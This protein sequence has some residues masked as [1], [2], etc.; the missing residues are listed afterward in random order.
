MTI[1]LNPERYI[2]KVLQR[3]GTVNCKPMKTPLPTRPNL[4]VYVEDANT[5]DDF[6]IGTILDDQL[7]TRPDLAYSVSLLSQFSANPGRNHWNCVRH[8]IRYLKR[9]KSM[10][11]CYSGSDSLNFH[12]FK[13][14]YF[15]ADH[16]TEKSTIGHVFMMS[17]GAV[18]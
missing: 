10:E 1:R 4:E 13:D 14:S 5:D 16:A 18:I 11:L 7:W 6:S 17:G 9:T 3:F 8:I 2:N 12:G 15:A